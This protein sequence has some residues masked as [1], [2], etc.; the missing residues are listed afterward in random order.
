ML[1][2]PQQTPKCKTGERWAFKQ[3]S[4]GGISVKVAHTVPEIV[5]VYFF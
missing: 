2:G 4:M 1:S 3:I 5:K